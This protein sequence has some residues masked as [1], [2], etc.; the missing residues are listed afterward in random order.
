MDNLTPLSHQFQPIYYHIGL[1][2]GRTRTLYNIQN[3][4]AESIRL[5]REHMEFWAIPRSKTNYIEQ[6]QL[7]LIIYRGM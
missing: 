7:S 3:I 4:G 5:C 6:Y 1:T 2:L